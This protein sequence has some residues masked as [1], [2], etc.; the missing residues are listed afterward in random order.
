[1]ARHAL[2][3][4]ETQTQMTTATEDLDGAMT[5]ELI[6]NRQHYIVKDAASYAILKRIGLPLLRIPQDFL[7][8]VEGML[9]AHGISHVV[10]G[11]APTV[12]E[13]WL[14]RV[15]RIWAKKYGTSKANGD[16][17]SGSITFI[18]SC[19][20]DLDPTT[21]EKLIQTKVAIN[22]LS[23]QVTQFF[24]RWGYRVD[25]NYSETLGGTKVKLH[26]EYR[27][28]AD[29]MPVLDLETPVQD[30]KEYVLQFGFSRVVLQ[31]D[32]P[33]EKSKRND[34]AYVH[35]RYEVSQG[36]KWSTI[37]TTR[38]LPTQISNVLPFVNALAKVRE[39]DIHNSD[40]EAV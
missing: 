18:A 17:K 19:R 30:L 12:F 31:F 9:A 24:Q 1:M 11:F 14:E 6:K 7:P 32:N 8:T 5:L 39:L 29:R 10:Q 2:L 21:D 34:I 16:T 38:C 23:D 33:K 13:P 37:N 40:N 36:G 26:V 20:K 28:E 35:I 3:L 25:V 22:K 4:K 15:T 27:F